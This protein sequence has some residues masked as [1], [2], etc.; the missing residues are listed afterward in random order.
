M[1]SNTQTE[2]DKQLSK[3][4]ENQFWHNCIHVQA[5]QAQVKAFIPEPD[6]PERMHRELDE[7]LHKF[8]DPAVR[9]PLFGTCL[10][11]KDV[12]FTDAFPTRAGSWLPEEAFSGAQ[13]IAV[14]QLLNAGALLLGKTACNEF[15][16]QKT[17]L[18][19]N[20]KAPGHSPGGSS[21]GSA[22]AVAAS[23]CD[24][25]L[26]SQSRAGVILPAAFCGVLGFKPSAGRFSKQG[27]FPFS[28]S[29]DQLGLFCQD[30]SLL[31]TASKVLLLKAD[32]AMPEDS[33]IVL[34]IPHKSFLAQADTDIL[35]HFYGQL[36][37][38]RE[39]GYTIVESDCFVGYQEITR[40]HYDLYAAEFTQNHIPLY[41]K[42][43]ALY[44][45]SARELFDSGLKIAPANLYFARDMQMKER[46][47]AQD[48]MR[49]A[50]ISILLSPSTASL[51]PLLNAEA[52]SRVMS[53]PFSFCGLPCLNLPLSNHP[54]G[55][56]V[57]LQISSFAGADEFLLSSAATLIQAL[58][59][60][61]NPE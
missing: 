47:L 10:G 50:G 22:A 16:Y 40:Y 61:K 6:L 38:L 53:L 5:S 11:V 19:I 15:S 48:I 49:Q 24:L 39:A 23:M 18:T 4:L 32:I 1:I 45:P 54:S 28:Q 43:Q 46:D 14:S 42:Y 7:L 29:L 34:G 13:S 59:Y 57:G 55:L 52:A 3:E 36:D 25:A 30:H 9:P 33:P 41:R 8:P 44:S 58:A 60:K 27:I 26:G 12:F 51:P 56:P 20:P 37:I 35:S 2:N 17:P 31:L 21:A